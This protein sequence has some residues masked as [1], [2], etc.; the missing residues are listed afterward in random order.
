VQNKAVQEAFTGMRIHG[1]DAC[2]VV[3]NSRFTKGAQEAAAGTGC[4]LIGEEEFPDLVIGNSVLVTS[5]RTH[6]RANENQVP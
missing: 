3:T 6:T 4:I 1:C 2:A 5:F